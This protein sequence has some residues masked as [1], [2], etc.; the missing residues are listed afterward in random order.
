MVDTWN[1]QWTVILQNET[2]W[3]KHAWEDLIILYLRDII[4]HR[5]YPQKNLH[6]HCFRFL[7]GHLHVPGEIGNNDHAKIW[8]GKRGVL[9]G[10][11]QVENLP[12]NQEFIFRAWLRYIILC[13]H[14]PVITLNLLHLLFTQWRY[15][16]ADSEKDCA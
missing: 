10:F 16:P 13:T 3:E 9:L 4:I 12:N 5:F 8:G 15:C 11:V 7:L 1:C 6:R 14:F 2:S